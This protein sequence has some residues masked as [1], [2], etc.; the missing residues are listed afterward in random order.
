MPYI[1]CRQKKTR[2]KV[3]VSACEGCKGMACPDY[4]DYLQLSLFPHLIPDE[5]VRRK[6]QSERRPV[7]NRKNSK[8]PQQISWLEKAD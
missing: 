7:E 8:S 1:T 5:K 4:Y 2:H 6:L 3:D